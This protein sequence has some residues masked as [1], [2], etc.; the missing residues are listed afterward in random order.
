MAIRPQTPLEKYQTDLAH[1]LISADPAQQK[2][3]VHTQRLYEDLL[4]SSQARPN[5]FGKLLR[6]KPQ[7]VKGLYFWGGVGRGKTYILD[8]FYE[9]LPFS[10]KRR[11]HFSTFFGGIHNLLSTLPRSPDPLKVIA[12]RIADETR[13]LC[14]DE[15]HVD[16]ITDAM[17]IAGLLE[18]L[19]ARGVVLVT[20]SNIEVTQLYKNGLQR[21]RFLP[22]ITLLQQYTE[23]VHLEGETDYRKLLLEKHGTYHINAPEQQLEIEFKS[24]APENI[25]WRFELILN[26]RPISAIAQSAD[27]AWFDF[28]QLCNTPRSSSDY[29]ALA[30]TYHTVMLSN[31]PVMGEGNNDIAQRFIQLIDALYD[32]KVKLIVAATHS[33]ENLYRGNT[34]AFPFQRTASRLHEMRSQEYLAS[35]HRG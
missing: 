26:R 6:K 4:N 23:I 20:S 28:D 2:A 16:D 14:I 12:K 3:V 32:H 31:V 24:L 7:I 22:A 19:F 29:I 34:L 9:C 13:I 8:S 21:D 35:A 17:I 27:I 15:F 33:P 10:A 18:A 25:R 11:E 1:Q 30:K 5:L